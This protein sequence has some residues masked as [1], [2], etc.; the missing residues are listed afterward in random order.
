MDQI[1]AA[2]ADLRLQQSTNI[3]ATA[4]RYGVDRSTL[5]R[6][7]RV[8]RSREEGYDS[9]RILSLAQSEA[10]IDHINFQLPH[11]LRLRLKWGQF[12]VDLNG[13]TPS[14]DLEG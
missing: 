4:S 8:T 9:Q 12:C 14:L 5:S 13:G 3:K 11:S 10:L 7:W 6:R 2:I 1:D